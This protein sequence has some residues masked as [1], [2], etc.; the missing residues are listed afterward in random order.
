MKKG[1]LKIKVLN[2]FNRQID[3]WF[4][5]NSLQDN[6]ARTFAKTIVKANQN[7][8]DTLIDLMTDNNGEVLVN[9]LLENFEFQDITI[10]LTQY[11]S[12]LP[13]KIL[14]FSRSDFEALKNELKNGD[15]KI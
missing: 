5:S 6:I 4:D 7:K 9:E 8:F 12:L 11:S 13:R 1:E 15:N 10:D 3:M 14:I 2:Y